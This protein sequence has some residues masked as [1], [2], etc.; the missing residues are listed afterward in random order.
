MKDYKKI[1]CFTAA[2][3][4]LGAA[5][6]CGYHIY[7][8]Y[9]HEAEQTEAFEEIAAIVE[10]AQTEDSNAPEVP[11]TEEENVL[12]EYGELF[13]K[14]TDMVGWLSISFPMIQA[15]STALRSLSPL[16]QAEYAQRQSC[17]R[18][19]PLKILRVLAKTLLFCWSRYARLIRNG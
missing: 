11:L 13:L 4:L 18:I 16:S 15:T 5:A 2:V 17:P 19:P 14:N 9:S 10:Q 8:H 12:A 1:I 6:F 3:C 7:D